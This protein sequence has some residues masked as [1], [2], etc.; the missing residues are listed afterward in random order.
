MVVVGMLS[1]S[2]LVVVGRWY[3]IQVCYAMNLVSGMLLA[4]EYSFNVGDCQGDVSTADMDYANALMQNVGPRA[5]RAACEHCD[6]H[7]KR[8]PSLTLL[9]LQCRMVQLA[10]PSLTY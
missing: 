5:W 10:Q 4:W 1:C 7:D 3:I 9:L 2:Q 8:R 6:S